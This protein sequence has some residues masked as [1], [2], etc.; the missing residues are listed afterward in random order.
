MKSI[1]NYNTFRE[2]SLP[3]SVNSF[4][5]LVDVKPKKLEKRAE[6]RNKG[7]IIFPSQSKD[8]ATPSSSIVNSTCNLAAV[9]KN[10]KTNLSIIQCKRK[11]YKHQN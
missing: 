7:Y 1:S 2:A 5:S 10:E 4:K 6:S 8:L 3:R 11:K 9:C